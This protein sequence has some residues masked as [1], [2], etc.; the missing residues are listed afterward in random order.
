MFDFGV[1]PPM[2]DRLSKARAKSEA[3]SAAIDLLMDALLQS[4]VPEERKIELRIARETKALTGK[5]HKSFLAFA[6]P[7]RDEAKTAE[8]FPVRK[9]V[10]EYIRLVSAGIDSFLEAHPVPEKEVSFF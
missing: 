2:Q 1:T 9:E 6:D 10:L 4:D 7:K 5:I 3:E 8:L